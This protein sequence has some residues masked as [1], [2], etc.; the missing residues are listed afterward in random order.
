MARC[1]LKELLRSPLQSVSTTGKPENLRSI[2]NGGKL[3]KGKCQRG[4]GLPIGG[5]PDPL[6][7]NL[8]ALKKC[9]D[10]MDK[11]VAG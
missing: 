4:L 11:M 6:G 8:G 7:R 3:R 2:L 5:K 1:A 10:L 9:K